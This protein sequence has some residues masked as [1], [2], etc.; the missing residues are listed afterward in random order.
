MRKCLFSS[1]CLFVVLTTASSLSAET[2][3]VTVVHGI[4]GVTVDVYVNGALTLP[5]F[6]PGTVTDEIELPEGDYDLALTLPGGDLADAILTGS[7]SVACDANASIVAHLDESGGPTISV[8]A[9]DLSD[10]ARGKGRLVVRHLAAAPTVDLKLKWRRWTVARFED[11][12]N[13]GEIS[14]NLYRTT[15]SASLYAAG[16]RTRVFGPAKIEIDRRV[17][18]IVYAI[19]SLADESFGVLVQ[20]Y[21]IPEP[22]PQTGEVS[23][24]HGVPGLTVDVYLNGELALPGFEPKTVTDP[25]ELPN[26]DYEIAVTAAG[27]NVANAVITASA[28]VVGGAN[29]TAVA[30][31]DADGAPTLSQFANDLSRARFL[32][33]RV[34]ARPTPAAPTGRVAEIAGLSNGEQAA[35]DLFLGRYAATVF[36]GGGEEPVAGPVRVK[37]RPRSSTIVYAI[38]SLADETLDFVVQRLPLARR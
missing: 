6:E 11:L 27:E 7:A 13:G 23:V 2:G 32:R 15:Y 29:V 30:H 20:T 14:A 36:P 17:G 10:I 37:V 22:V 5:G 4:P 33:G 18:T 26:G 31:L 34:V 21:D 3:A 35:A 38:G 24:V 9:N 28:T 1:F 25:I 16:T 12:S 19:G 8:F